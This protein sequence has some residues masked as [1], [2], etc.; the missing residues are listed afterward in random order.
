M[1]NIIGIVVSFVYIAVLM[2]TAKYFEKWDKE[3]SRK[4]IHILLAN[5]WLIAMAF[6]DSVVWAMIPPIAFVVINFASY[7]LNLIKVMERDE[8]TEDGIGTVYFAASLIPL[9]ILS[10]GVTHNPLIGLIGFFAMTYGDGFAALVGKS[11]KSKE[12]QIFGCTKT[13]AGSIAMFVLS[14]LITIAVFAYANVEMWLLKSILI[15]VVATIL[16]AISIKGTDNLTV[17]I[18]SSVIAYF[19]MM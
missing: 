1:K 8:T 16:E 14:W 9:V 4:F 19:M 7:K 13:I 10:F 12:Y 11:V 18:A 6:F 2:V 3:A 5:W 17:P 15:A